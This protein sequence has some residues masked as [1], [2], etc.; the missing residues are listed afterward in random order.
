MSTART[1]DQTYVKTGQV[2]VVSKNLPVH[3]EQAVTLATAALCASDQN[4]FWE[5][6][7]SLM[8]GFY[9]GRLD[10]PDL[11]NLGRR[12]ADLGLDTM[13][14]TS[15]LAE[16]K[17]LSRVEAEAAE[18]E[19]LGVTGTPTFFVNNTRLVGA[20]PFTA[21]KTAIDNALK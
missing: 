20:L 12:A 7:D 2:K 11:T 15:C 10:P 21:F 19:Q 17:Y 3:G 9:L 13:A 4:K 16:G 18:G 6:H 1:I 14:F 5:F 8:E